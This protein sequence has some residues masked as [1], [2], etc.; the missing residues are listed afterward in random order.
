MEEDLFGNIQIVFGILLIF[1]LVAQFQQLV[2][3]APVQ[4]D[5][6]VM[7]VIGLDVF[8]HSLLWFEVVVEGLGDGS[9]RGEDLM[10]LVFFEGGKLGVIE[11]IL[12]DVVIV[13]LIFGYSAHFE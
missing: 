4:T 5:G 11:Q 7:V 1:Q 13:V 8:D 3:E 2:I 10:G 12:D 6:D 9:G